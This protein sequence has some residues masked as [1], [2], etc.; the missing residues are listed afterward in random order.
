M[1]L[2][3]NFPQRQRF[4][5]V[6]SSQWEEWRKQK[7]ETLALRF[8][9]CPIDHSNMLKNTTAFDLTIVLGGES[10]TAHR[11]V[12]E[13]RCPTLLSHAVKRKLIKRGS[14]L[15]ELEKSPITAKG[16][17]MLLN[18]I[19]SA[20]IP[21]IFS[22]NHVDLVELMYIAKVYDQDKLMQFCR[23]FMFLKLD[24]SNWFYIV[25]NTAPT[26]LN[27]PDALEICKLY[28]SFHL[29]EIV[30]QKQGILALGVELF[31]EMID[32]ICNFEDFSKILK[33]VDALFE[34]SFA[35]LIA[36]FKK[37]HKDMLFA[38]AFVRTHNSDNILCHSNLLL[39]QSQQFMAFFKSE[40]INTV[41]LVEN[42]P[43][44]SG[45]AFS[46]LLEYLYFNDISKMNIL[47]ARQLMQ[48]TTDF[49]LRK[50]RDQCLL[51][52]KEGMSP[53]SLVHS[54]EIV[55][56][57]YKRD[58]M[59]NAETEKLL[60]ECMDKILATFR[61]VNFTKLVHSSVGVE[62]LVNFQKYAKGRWKSSP[63][64]LKYGSQERIFLDR[65]KDQARLLR[66]DSVRARKKKETDGP[67]DILKQFSRS[68]KK[69]SKDKVKQRAYSKSDRV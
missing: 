68:D 13:A 33:D 16:M 44:L 27:I 57:F 45:E 20:N 50:L 17:R 66:L 69:V 10:I 14:V 58:A 28:A 59:K 39:G 42:Y 25:K 8:G 49:A 56:E 47:F 60:K 12:I 36:D 61:E 41:N 32:F 43:F 21:K 5:K 22:I 15:V 26:K 52:S 38:D 64:P 67:N 9:T 35:S 29:H 24:V 19:Y 48:F 51:Q 63:E 37:I 4:V 7:L 3:L 2:D 1:E 40:S 53:H 11:F 54:L 23:W 6:S 18:W 55:T 31:H 30:A 65:N 62:I 46:T 34:E